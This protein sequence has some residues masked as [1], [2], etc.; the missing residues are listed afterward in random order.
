MKTV[1]KE[2]FDDGTLT[3]FKP[4]DPKIGEYALLSTYDDLMDTDKKVLILFN[5]IPL[6][7][8]ARANALE[9]WVDVRI[10]R[11]VWSDR[12]HYVKPNNNPDT[13]PITVRIAGKVQ[14]IQLDKTTG[15]PIVRSIF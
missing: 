1:L 12:I 8:A 10:V 7:T 3:D 14:I 2:I 11:A 6:L 5:D 4:I 15:K 13:Y 9:N